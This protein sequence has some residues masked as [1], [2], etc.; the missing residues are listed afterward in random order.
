MGEK[1]NVVGHYAVGMNREGMGERVRAQIVEEP[2]R[3]DWLS[4]DFF[5][6]FAAESYEEPGPT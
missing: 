2:L 4:E 6:I 5:S 1:V 3:A